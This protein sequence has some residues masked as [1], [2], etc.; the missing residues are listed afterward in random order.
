M[1]EIKDCKESGLEDALC[2]GKLLECSIESQRGQALYGH[3]DEG[4]VGQCKNRPHYMVDDV[5]MCRPHASR[6]ALEACLAST[7]KR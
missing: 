3:I 7:S 5:P 6:A 2:G 1:V 4:R